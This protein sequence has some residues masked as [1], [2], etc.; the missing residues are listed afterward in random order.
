[1]R[2]KLLQPFLVAVL[3]ITSALS[4]NSCKKDVVGDTHQLPRAIENYCYICNRDLTPT[5]ESI[6]LPPPLATTAYSCYHEYALGE[7]CPY[8]FCNLY[9]RH[10]YHFF[11]VGHDHN[12]FFIVNE[13]IGGGGGSGD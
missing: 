6:P 13:H 9:P 1:M 11:Y 10:H 5:P 4:F 2:K 12:Q 3:L 7:S 8:A